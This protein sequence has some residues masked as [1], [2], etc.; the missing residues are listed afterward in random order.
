MVKLTDFF[1]VYE[2]NGRTEES[3]KKCMPLVLP[4]LNKQLFG[5][6]ENTVATIV[7]LEVDDAQIVGLFSSPLSFCGREASADPSRVYYF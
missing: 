1:S 7:D 6:G 3:Y 4:E 5:S 2:P